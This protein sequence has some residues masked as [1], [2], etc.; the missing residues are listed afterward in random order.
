MNEQ[1]LNK[2]AMGVLIGIGFM[3]ALGAIGG[4]TRQEAGTYQLDC[5]TRGYV[6]VLNTQT[7]RLWQTNSVGHWKDCGHAS[8]ME[9][10]TPAKAATREAGRLK[11]K[12]TDESLQTENH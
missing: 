9:E 5:D 11:W 1:K 3:L 12:S 7:G 6:Y 8:G 4:G 10:I 2:L